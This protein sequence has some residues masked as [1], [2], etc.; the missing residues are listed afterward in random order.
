MGLSNRKRTNRRFNGTKMVVNNTGTASTIVPKN[1]FSQTNQYNQISPDENNFIPCTTNEGLYDPNFVYQQRGSVNVCLDVN[2]FYGKNKLMIG[3]N[4]GLSVVNSE[5]GELI[6]NNDD[7]KPI[8]SISQLPINQYMV[9]GNFTGF[10]KKINSD[11]TTD[12]SFVPRF[13]TNRLTIKSIVKFTPDN[14]ILL[15]M[16]GSSN[17]FK[18]GY[19]GSTTNYYQQ[20]YK[21]NTDGTIDTDFF[22]QTT[23]NIDTNTQFLPANLAIVYGI[24]IVPSTSQELYKIYIVGRFDEYQEVPT[25]NFCSIDQNGQIDDEMYSPFS[26]INDYVTSIKYVGNGKLLIGGFFEDIQGYNYLLRYDV[27]L[28]GGFGDVDITFTKNNIPGP[29][30]SIQIDT[31]NKILVSYNNLEVTG[32]TNYIRLNFD[33]SADNT[34][35]VENFIPQSRRLSSEF[36]YKSSN[37]GYFLRQTGD[38]FENGVKSPTFMKLKGC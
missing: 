7:L 19:T 38:S 23:F 6:N 25:F 1:D 5:S 31:D 27:N 11:L 3:T 15:Y 16:K 4:I 21:L 9:T 33:G 24:E 17:P 30:T 37:G 26:N 18:I 32:T 36:I 8:L 20:I 13:Q 35:N 29:V 2:P 22:N 12:N 10:I 28:D 34:F 14:K